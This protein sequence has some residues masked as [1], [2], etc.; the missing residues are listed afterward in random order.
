MNELDL[1]STILSEML[2][3]SPV[4]G[5]LAWLVWYFTKQIDKKQT[6]NNEL[7]KTLME[8]HRENIEVISKLTQAIELMSKDVQNLSK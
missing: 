1:F 3:V 5:L 2:K 8:L 4:V 6:E 7:Q